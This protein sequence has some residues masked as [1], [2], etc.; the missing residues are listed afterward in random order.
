MTKHNNL[1]REIR[2]RMA[3]I[4]E[5]YTEARRFVFREH[6]F[7]VD[8]QP[9]PETEHREPIVFEL[10]ETEIKRLFQSVDVAKLHDQNINRLGLCRRRDGIELICARCRIPQH[11]NSS[12]VGNNVAD[13]L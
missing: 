4:G 9:I 12:C 5:P 6:G 7:A 3:L 13:L 2:E 11:S 1:K 10:T 8:A